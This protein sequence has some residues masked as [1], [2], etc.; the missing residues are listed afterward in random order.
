MTKLIVIYRNFA[1]VPK[2]CDVLSLA[3]WD[4]KFRSTSH[5]QDE[6]KKHVIQYL[7]NQLTE[8]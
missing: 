7:L 2:N 5:S 1:K 6:E 8:I 3:I 4:P